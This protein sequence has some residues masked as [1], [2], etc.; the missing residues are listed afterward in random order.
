MELPRLEP[1]YQKYRDQG[2]SV[3][4]I[5]NS[6]NRQGAQK[7]LAEN[8]L[9][10]PCLENGEGDAEIVYE[11]FH[12]QGMPTSYILDAEGRVLFKHL[13]FSKGDEEKMEEEIK[14]VMEG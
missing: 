8:P 5:E 7:W 6:R 11:L 4:A 13:G 3:I 10:Y 9:S 2:L 14:R 12:V 1:L